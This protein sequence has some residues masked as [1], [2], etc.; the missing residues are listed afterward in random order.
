MNTPH[1]HEATRAPDRYDLCGE[2][3]ALDSRHPGEIM[4]YAMEQGSRPHRITVDEY[5]RMEEVGQLAPEARVELIEGVIVDMAPIGPVHA[6]DVDLIAERFVM[7]VLGKVIVRVQGPVQ[8][9]EDTLLV[10]DVALLRRQADGYS[11]KHPSPSDI[12]L[13]FEVADSSVDYDFGRKLKL[14]A[15]YGVQEVWILNVRT[16]TLHFFRSRTDVGYREEGSTKNPGVLPLPTIGLT[17][18]LSGLART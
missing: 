16:D 12:F 9:N 7:A 18:D 1:L 3:L 8:L 17:V 15:R 2:R 6:R 4:S 11:G 14:Y 13:V 10:P 5:I